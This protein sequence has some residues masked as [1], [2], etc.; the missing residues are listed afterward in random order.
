MG[1]RGHKTVRAGST[2]A[3]LCK[4]RQRGR[5]EA[6]GRVLLGKGTAGTRRQDGR[7][8]GGLPGRDG[9]SL[10]GPG[11]GIEE[12]E[13][14]K[15]D[16]GRANASRQGGVNS[17]HKCWNLTIW[18]YESKPGRRAQVCLGPWGRGNLQSPQLCYWVVAPVRCLSHQ[19]RERKHPCPW[20]QVSIT[21][22]TQSLDNLGLVL[23]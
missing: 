10:E 13:H 15:G 16:E 23:L 3:V 4:Q 20:T 11:E 12:E 18:K 22:D 1:S 7:N 17:S 21:G 14:S 6:S 2:Q 8:Q 19:H 9:R 5:V